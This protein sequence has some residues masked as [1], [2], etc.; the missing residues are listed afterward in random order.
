MK[1]TAIRQGYVIKKIFPLAFSN[2]PFLFFAEIVLFL[3]YS[4]FGV[5]IISATSNIFALVQLKATF[6]DELLKSI[7]LLIIILILKELTGALSDLI[8]KY[9]CEISL[10]KFSELTHKKTR[11]IDTIVFENPNFLDLV[12]KSEDGVYAVSY[13]VLNILSLAFYDTPYL[14]LIGLY[15]MQIKPIL[16]LIPFCVCVP[17]ILNQLIKT[18]YQIK[19]KDEEAPLNRKKNS[20]KSYICELEY[21]KETRHLGCFRY[22][23]SL[24]MYVSELL[25]KKQWKLYSKEQVVNI[26]NKVITLSGYLVAIL[27]LYYSLMDNSISISIFATVFY[28]LK[29]V[30]SNIE[31]ILSNRIAPII[32]DDFSSIVSFIKFMEL[33]HRKF[34]TMSIESIDSIEAKN[35]SFTYPGRDEP[36]I[37]DIDFKLK[38]GQLITLVGENGSGKTTLS[39]LILGLYK[40]A[41]GH[42]YI[43]NV[44]SNDITHTSLFKNKSA[45]FQNFYKYYFNLANNISISDFNSIRDTARLNRIS[46][47]V[48]IN[49]NSNVFPDGYDTILSKNFGGIDLSGGEWQKVAIA[50]GY[51]RNND[52]IVL[53]EPTAMIDPIQEDKMYS[54]ILNIVKNDKIVIVITHRMA[55]VKQSDVVIYMQGGKIIQKG[56]H[57]E[58]LNNDSYREFFSTQAKWYQ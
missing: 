32:T 31:H 49:V 56:T 53:D 40:P 58:L 17:V 52:I 21:F 18:K 35:I 37:S 10:T 13:Y 29:S 44:D 7:S 6:D 12:E 46:N 45:V 27:M 57:K 4:S 43:N 23:Y 42:I 19:Y 25:I 22:F 2:S 34:G 36:A 3:I 20:Y 16:F 24:Y 9:I 28:S 55:L 47:E 15:L 48:G 26:I 54:D 51:Y 5:A 11:T 39:K 30:H 8:A 50:R 33:P 41:K 14:M 38:K 1:K